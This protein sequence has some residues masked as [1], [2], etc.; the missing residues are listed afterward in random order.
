MRYY[1]VPKDASDPAGPYE[2]DYGSVINFVGMG[3]Y[4]VS[5]RSYG[6]HC[7]CYVVDCGLP[8]AFFLAAVANMME[9]E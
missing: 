6:I 3:G 2:I 1:F 4:I 7:P 9:L 8:R 5:C